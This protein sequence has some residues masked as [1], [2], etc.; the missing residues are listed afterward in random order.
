LIRA[1]SSS[2]GW[3]RLKS[4]SVPGSMWWRWRSNSESCAIA[5]GI[6]SGDRAEVARQ[7]AHSLDEQ[8]PD[9]EPERH[10]RGPSYRLP[11]PPV[12]RNEACRGDGP[13]TVVE[14]RESCR[15]RPP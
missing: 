6:A 9:H 5:C 11:R 12:T 2:S 4:S 3:R 15:G 10:G 14:D 8:Q 13:Q 1:C 7:R